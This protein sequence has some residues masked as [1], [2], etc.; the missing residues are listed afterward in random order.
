M[1]SLLKEK[2]TDVKWGEWGLISL[3]IS[4]LSGVVVAFQY[5]P[6]TP[7]YSASSLDVLVPFGDYFRS[8]HFYSSQLF[9]L[10][11]L[12]HLWAIFKRC[13]TYN[14]A[15]WIRLTATLPVGLL[16]LFSGYVLRG[17]ST[18]TSAGLIAE[19]IIIA[20]PG[21]GGA[22]NDLLFS[23]SDD[24]MK[25]VYVNHVIGFGL[26]W[27]VLAWEH[28]RKYRTS[29][30]QHPLLTATIL[31]FCLLFTAPFEP[32]T[33]GLLQINGPWFFLGLQ[34]LLRFLPPLL[35]GVIFPS[36]LILALFFLQPNSRYSHSL[37]TFILGWLGLYT[38]LSAVALCR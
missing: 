10:L 20:I 15:Q 29:F 5:D 36:T 24:G 2:L 6:A 25:R 3:F 31:L 28:L 7:L 22:L 37:L 14:R 16:L 30:R 18:G 33:L 32:E 17:D 26:I 23:I 19:N 4:V 21:A 13:D 11:S 12:V 38:V 34:E 9:F 8:L 35:A 27:G 1:N